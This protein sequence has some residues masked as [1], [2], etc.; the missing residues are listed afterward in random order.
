MAI[1]LD[2]MNL[3]SSLNMLTIILY[4]L[5]RSSRFTPSLNGKGYPNVELAKNLGFN[6]GLLEI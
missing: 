1:F 2:S 4:P 5:R 3:D 6:V